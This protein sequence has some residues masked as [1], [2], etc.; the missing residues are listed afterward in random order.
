M[1]VSNASTNAATNAAERE[2]VITRVF[3]AP[4][5][6]VFKTWTDPQHVAKA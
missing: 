5:D 4:R 3:A 1:A 2:L 6:L